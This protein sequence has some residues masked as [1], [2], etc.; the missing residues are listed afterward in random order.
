MSSVSSSHPEGG[1]VG[2]PPPPPPPQRMKLLEE[3]EEEAFGS[4]AGGGKFRDLWQ[5]QEKYVDYLESKVRHLREDSY[6]RENLLLMRLS[7]KEQ[8]INELVNQ[9]NELKKWKN[10][11]F[12]NSA[13]LDPAV[14]LILSRLRSELDSSRKKMMEIQEELNAWKFTPDS[15]T[16]KRLMAKCRQLL[17]EN[18]DI[19]KMIA[20]GRLAKLEGEL[21]MTKKLAAEMTKN[22][23]E[24]DE[25]VQELDEDVEGM[26]ST[27]Y[28][29]QQQ[30]KE[31]NNKLA[32]YSKQNKDVKTE[33][34]PRNDEEEEEEE[35]SSNTKI[36]SEEP[37]SQEPEEG[38]KNDNEASMTEES[39]EQKNE[40][41]KE[42][43]EQLQSQQTDKNNSGKRGGG[44]KNAKSNLTDSPR[45]STRGQKRENDDETEDSGATVTPSKGRPKRRRGAK[46][47]DSSDIT[48]T[49]DSNNT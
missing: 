44:R 12:K 15:G 14:N 48:V 1:I 13:V 39:N 46:D 26:Q 31:A 17:Q 49:E 40:S 34:N 41:E 9:I 23:L 42:E 6:K 22:Q 7:G 30:L 45:R 19:G 32:Q 43:N 35:S 36:E 4:G 18:E 27:I 37:L 20:S 28:Y 25:F 10:S 8:D 33:N 5:E 24:M 21:A 3:D 29:L 16:G 11:S 2:P 47:D 38:D